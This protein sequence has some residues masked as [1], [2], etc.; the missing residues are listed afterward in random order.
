MAADLTHEEFSSHLNTKFGIR[1][2]EAQAIEAELTEVSEHMISPRQERFS[3]VFR[4]SNEA[5]LG[6]GM[7]RFE[8][9]QMGSFNL[10]IVPIQRDETGT[11]YESVFN[12]LVKKTP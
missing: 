1:L 5:L 8:H 3:I 7:H 9:E 10:F 2:S 4:T 11:Y 12:R 6:Q